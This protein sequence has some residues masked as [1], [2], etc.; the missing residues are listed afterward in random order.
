[1]TDEEVKNLSLENAMA[2]KALTKT[3]DGVGATVSEW[4]RAMKE[5]D[6]EIKNAV[7]E[8]VKAQQECKFQSKLVEAQFKGKKEQ[9]ADTRAKL[10]TKASKEEVKSLKDFI[11]K[12]LWW[13][14]GG[15]VGTIVFL[16]KQTVFNS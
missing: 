1:M 12:A 2:I 4:A 14:F 10:A 7:T 9:L 6:K 11:H 15:L 3:I 5:E 8:L 13:L 16:L